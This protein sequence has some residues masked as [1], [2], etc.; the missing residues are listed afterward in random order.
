MS[1][2]LGSLSGK[3]QRT[4]EDL[5][6]LPETSDEDEEESGN[7]E[8]ISSRPTTARATSPS[9]GNEQGLTR[10]FRQG[11]AG[12]IPWFEEMIEGSRLGR[13]MKSRRGVGVSDDQSTSIEWEISEWSTDGSREAIQP[14]GK[15]KRG[16]SSFEGGSPQKRK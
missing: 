8:V 4:L 11:T 9:A 12:G 6:L 3:D 1:V 15:R 14:A 5:D 13:L 16:H 7:V 10:S 2:T